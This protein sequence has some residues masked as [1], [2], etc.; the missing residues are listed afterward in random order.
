[1]SAFRAGLIGALGLPFAE[2]VLLALS[3]TSWGRDEDLDQLLAAA[4]TLA[5]T[6]PA[7][8]RPVL[9]LA[10]GDGEGRRGFEA[11]AA[12]IRDS[13]AAVRTTFVSSDQYPLLVRSADVGISLHRPAAGLDPPMKVAD[14][15]GGGVPVL[16]LRD[17]RTPESLIVDGRN[18]LAFRGPADLA[19]AL[20]R[21]ASDPASLAALAEGA[22][23]SGYPSFGRAWASEAAP[24]LLGSAG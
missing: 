17:G 7:A 16:E 8:A 13:R 18:G 14:L 1:V 15:L 23:K 5:S 20:A 2:P 21:L 11:K 4:G 24:V 22:R 9:L 3:P 19:G 6:L 10:S 12:S